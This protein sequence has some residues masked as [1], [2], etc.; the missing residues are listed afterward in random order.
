MALISCEECGKEVSDKA[1]SCVNCGAPIPVEFPHNNSAVKGVV[2]SLLF[3]IGA[4]VAA[5]SIINTLILIFQMVTGNIDW[6]FAA[7]GITI[8]ILTIF[9]IRATRSIYR[10]RWPSNKR[11]VSIIFIWFNATALSVIL[12]EFYGY[13]DLSFE[14]IFYIIGVCVFIDI[15]LFMA[16]YILKK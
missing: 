3:A 16:M 14:D 6:G 15:I 7:T 2:L 1:E 10:K 9:S 13:S 8:N 11:A 5:L 4:V 12:S